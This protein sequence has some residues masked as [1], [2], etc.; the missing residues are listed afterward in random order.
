MLILNREKALL[1]TM[2]RYAAAKTRMEE[3]S[4][5]ITTHSKEVTEIYKDIHKVESELLGIRNTL[6]NREVTNEEDTS[7][8]KQLDEILEKRNIYR[9]LQY[10]YDIKQSRL[11]NQYAIRYYI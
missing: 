10:K 9:N 2:Q 7:S 5:I 3:L 4:S 11:H 8:E 6:I 1:P